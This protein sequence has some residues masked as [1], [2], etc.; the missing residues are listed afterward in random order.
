MQTLWLPPGDST[1]KRGPSYPNQSHRIPTTIILL[2]IF[3]VHPNPPIPYRQPLLISQS[4][5]SILFNLLTT[6]IP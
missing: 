6:L 1:G 3:S 4:L 5:V 2:L